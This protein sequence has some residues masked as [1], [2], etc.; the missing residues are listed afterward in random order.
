MIHLPAE[1][2]HEVITSLSTSEYPLQYGHKRDVQLALVHLSC[3]NHHLRDI[4]QPIL[5]ST[6][7]ISPENL[8]AY[9]STPPHLQ[10]HTTSLWLQSF[11]GKL[12][13]AADL[14]R[15]LGPSLRSLALD[16]PGNE[17]DAYPSVRQALS[18]CTNLEGFARSGYSPMQ[19]SQPRS[20]WPEWK[21]IRHLTLDGPLIDDKFI[22]HVENLPCLTHLA[23][24]EPRWKYGRDGTEAATF[25]RLLTSSSTL[26]RLLLIYCEAN[27][28]NLPSLM[29][30][31]SLVKLAGLREGLD[32]FY[33]ILDKV[34]TVM[35][36]IR[37]QIGAGTLWSL[38][39]HNIVHP[40]P[41][42]GKVVLGRVDT[43]REAQL[44][45]SEF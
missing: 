32:V 36:D 26:Q 41:G 15:V 9:L 17:L 42:K 27:Q 18:L 37:D 28:I 43:N 24:I 12:S 34:A 44:L 13:Q 6:I 39:S 23:L 20:F 2:I 33:M 35:S 8:H 11:A 21:H 14:I 10:K 31:R 40:L 30:L 29:R 4:A 45:P 16:I 25:L 22:G 38:H 1:L 5:Y 7:V 19:V 3:V